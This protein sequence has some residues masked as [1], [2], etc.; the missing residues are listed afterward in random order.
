MTAKAKIDI[1]VNDSKFKNVVEAMDKFNK[2]IKASNTSWGKASMATAKIA[3]QIKTQTKLNADVAKSIGTA[4]ANE[5]K[6]LATTIN[7]NTRLATTAKLMKQVAMYG[8]VMGGSAMRS[9]TNYMSR[10]LAGNVRPNFGGG[11]FGGGGGGGSFLGGLGGGLG[12]LGGPL[13]VVFRAITSFIGMAFN[14]VK[15]VAKFGI[16]AVAGLG[17]GAYALTG[18][19]ASDR[20]AAAN[21]GM[22]RGQLKAS[23]I[24][25]GTQYG[26][27][28]MG[29]LNNL[30]NLR[31]NVQG[32]TMLEKGLGLNPQENLFT[33]GQKVLERL[34]DLTKDKPQAL[35]QNILEGYG[36]KD[37]AT[38]EMLRIYRGTSPSVRADVTGRA[39]AFSISHGLSTGDMQLM[40]NARARFESLLDMVQLSFSKL[41]LKFEPTVERWVTGLEGWIQEVVSN[42]KIQTFVDAVATKIDKF[43]VNVGSIDEN[44]KKFG[45][46][47]DAITDVINK[48]VRIIKAPF[49]FLF[50]TFDAVG[51]SVNNFVQ[52]DPKKKTF[53]ENFS[54]DARNFIGST[55]NT[56]SGIANKMQE[57]FIPSSKNWASSIIESGTITSGFGKRI[58]GGKEQDHLGYDISNAAKKSGVYAYAGGELISKGT[59]NSRGNWVELSPRA[60]VS[61]KYY[62]LAEPSN[63]PIGAYLES[64]DKVGNMGNTGSSTGPHTHIQFSKNGEPVRV[65]VYNKLV[66]Q[67]KAG[68]DM[69]LIVGG[70]RNN[71]R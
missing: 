3:D 51:D 27:E 54:R 15:S 62:H 44:L 53:A 47:I 5:A 64:G 8:A 37:F 28:Y 48:S 56:W 6:L 42:N 49:E 7:L 65:E 23:E 71:T 9:G 60:G 34:D 17:Y 2:A 45:D 24:Y 40:T 26:P 13:M 12:A 11:G 20:R 16:G 29:Y 67:E 35:Q 10:V 18:A 55:G 32:A 66:L 38:L 58:L 63:L 21:L 33:L 52:S 57:H 41:F 59:D 14:F 43:S 31:S 4:V 30:A 61:E 25:Y 70:G 46:A 39:T 19:T 50:G 1:D 22:T 68:S 69:N 36:V